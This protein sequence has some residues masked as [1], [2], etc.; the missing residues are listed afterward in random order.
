VSSEVSD[1]SS[2]LVE[3]DF[4]VVDHLGAAIKGFQRSPRRT[5]GFG[6]F[7]LQMLIDCKRLTYGS[8]YREKL[9]GLPLLNTPC[10]I[11]N[12]ESKSPEKVPVIVLSVSV[13]TS[14]PAP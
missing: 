11:S 12:P 1:S 3:S 6:E 7:A 13:M 14:V 5:D 8:V 9:V 10:L 4:R 2:V